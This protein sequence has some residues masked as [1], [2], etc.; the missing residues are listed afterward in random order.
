MEKDIEALR[1]KAQRLDD[2][3]AISPRLFPLEAKLRLL[4]NELTVEDIIRE[5]TLNEFHRRCRSFQLPNEYQ[6]YLA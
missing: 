6:Q 4:K 2:D 1:Q 5:K 3:S